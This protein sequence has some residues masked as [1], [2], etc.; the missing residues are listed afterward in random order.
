MRLWGRM[1]WL[2]MNKEQILYILKDINGN[3]PVY[4]ENVLNDSKEDPHFSAVYVNNLIKCYIDLMIQ[5]GKKLPYRDVKS[6]ILF[7]GFDE[8]EYEFFENSRKNE[9]TYYIGE[10]F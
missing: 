7:N 3:L 8:S 5:M 2:L 1:V 10:Q 4:I 9:S 6:F